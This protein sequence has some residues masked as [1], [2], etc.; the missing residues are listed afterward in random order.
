MS[1]SSSSELEEQLPFLAAQADEA[2][3]AGQPAASISS[4][5]APLELQPRID[6]ALEC[7]NL[8]RQFWGTDCAGNGNHQA[9]EHAAGGNRKLPWQRLGRFEL[10]RELGRGGFG[11]VYLAYDPE[12]NREVALKVPRLDFIADPRLRARFKKEAKAAAGLDHP[13]IVAVYET[14][15]VGPVCYIAAAY[16][17][18]VTL[19]TWLHDRSRPVAA[20]EAASLIATLA[21]AVEHAHERGLLHRDLK[22]ANVLLQEANSQQSGPA[23]VY[24]ANKETPAAPKK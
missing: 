15:E 13:N 6:S 12:L 7:I 14:G 23:E 9:D 11:I 4:M 5:I 10:R 20:R 19:A 22:P 3:A 2:L 16:C 21:D 8:L 17:P 24:S 18:G 1:N